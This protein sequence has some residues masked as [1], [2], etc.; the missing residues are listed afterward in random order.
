MH[1]EKL[2]RLVETIVDVASELCSHMPK[3]NHKR[4]RLRTRAIASL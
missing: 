2:L 4:F 1:E 3:N